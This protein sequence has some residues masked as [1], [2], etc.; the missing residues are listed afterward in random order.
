MQW[1]D[2]SAEDL[3]RMIL[4][5]PEAIGMEPFLYLDRLFIMRKFFVMWEGGLKRF[6]ILSHVYVPATTY[7]FRIIFDKVLAV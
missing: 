5:R 2:S 7:T 6:W 4:C 1:T 3:N